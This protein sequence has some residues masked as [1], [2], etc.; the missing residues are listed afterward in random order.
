MPRKYC[1]GCYQKN[2]NNKNKQLVA[3][4]HKGQ[5]SSG[6]KYFTGKRLRCENHKFL[7]GAHGQV[8]CSSLV[9]VHK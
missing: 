6:M 9:Q 2:N 5:T 4:V 7:A 1:G 8:H 3:R